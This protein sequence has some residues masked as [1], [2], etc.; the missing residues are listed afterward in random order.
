[1]TRKEAQLREA[2]RAQIRKY[3]KEADEPD[4]IKKAKGPTKT[5][6]KKFEADAEFSKLTPP[7]KVEFIV[8]MI[9]KVGLDSTTKTETTKRTSEISCRS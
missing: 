4:Y 7:Q 1:M 2:L 3:L 5:A 8:S 9:K 6:L